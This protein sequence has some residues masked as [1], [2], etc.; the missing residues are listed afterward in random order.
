MLKGW[1]IANH[2]ECFDLTMLC[3]T[4]LAEI[5][6]S[7]SYVPFCYEEKLQLLHIKVNFSDLYLLE[8]RFKSIGE[9]VPKN[10]YAEALH[11]YKFVKDK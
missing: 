9:P 1:L 6:P 8:Q 7:T 3:I 11:Y 10:D 5:K 4:K 2:K